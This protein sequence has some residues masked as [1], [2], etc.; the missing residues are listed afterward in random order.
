MK[1]LLALLLALVL[2]LSL[3]PAAFAETD[4]LN[5]EARYA[6]LNKWS[7]TV[8]V[9]QNDGYWKLITLDG[10]LLV[11][12]SEK[13]IDMSTSSS[14]SFFTVDKE[15]ADGIHG[16]GLINGF[17]TVLVPAKYADVEIISDRWQAGITLVSSSAEDKDYTFSNW[18]TDEK[19]FYRVDKV[20]LYFDGQFVGSL[21]RAEYASSTA[22]GAYLAVK[23][24]SGVYKFYNKHFE[25]SPYAASYSSE[26]DSVYKSGTYTYY[27]QGSGQVA[28]TATCTLN[29][30]DLENPYLYDH[31]VVY[32]IRGEELFTT[33]AFDSVRFFD[34]YAVGRMNGKEGLISLDGREVIPPVYDEL[35]NYEDHPLRFGYISAVKDGKFGFLDAEGNATTTFTYSKDVVNNRGT[36]ATVKDLDG[37]IIVLSAAVG[38]LPDR[39]SDVSFPSYYGCMSFVAK[40]ANG[41][42]AV[43]DLFGNELLPFGSYG[44][45][46]LTVDGTAALVNPSYHQYTIYKFEI[47]R[48]ETAEE[49]PAEPAVED[50]WTCVNGHSGNHG[51]FCSFCGAAKPEEGPH[52]CIW[53][54]Y[55]FGDTDP[56][57][58]PNC[59]K[60]VK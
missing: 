55:D 3:V 25:A 10:D 37:S 56:S 14:Y 9:Q 11:P 4:A 6:I 49:A 28:F 52:K 8:A 13:Y 39:Y 7:N 48:P 23:D 2:V 50:G 34:G 22:H 17:G 59:G 26:Y 60:P 53:C 57:F 51:N 36:F 33:K 31:G 15:S 44:S 30:D 35:G 21:S 47:S 54:G 29:P 32:N 18:S 58:C 45:I 40:N 20:D 27:H 38:Q 5:F 12:A 46:D 24:R 1:K 43:I 42:Y 16:E 41:D 19:S